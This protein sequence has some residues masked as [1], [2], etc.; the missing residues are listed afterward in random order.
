MT[1][2]KYDNAL[3]SIIA[4]IQMLKFNYRAV[5]SEE[6]NAH[7]RTGEGNRKQEM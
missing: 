6:R 3:D 5:G 4:R 1:N 2:R 7:E